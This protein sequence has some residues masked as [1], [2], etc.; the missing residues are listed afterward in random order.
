MSVLYEPE[1]PAGQLGI[2]EKLS[3]AVLY[4]PDASDGQLG[5]RE[6][7][8]LVCFLVCIYSLRAGSVSDG[9]IGPRRAAG[10]RPLTLWIMPMVFWQF[11]D[12][13]ICP[14]LTRPARKVQKR[15]PSPFTRSPTEF[16]ISCFLTNQRRT[17]NPT[18]NS[19]HQRSSGS[20]QARNSVS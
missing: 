18:D 12:C 7:D 6:N 20:S 13:I 1:A 11:P 2:R 17:R 19:G 10:V 9:Q 16:V 14:S 15:S 4:E 3:P 5:I 8:C